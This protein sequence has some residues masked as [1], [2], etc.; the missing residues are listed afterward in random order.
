MV[1]KSKTTSYGLVELKEEYGEYRLYVNGTLK[2]YS[3]DLS[4]MIR[5]FEKA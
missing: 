4:F 2:S 3:S 1:L 5:E